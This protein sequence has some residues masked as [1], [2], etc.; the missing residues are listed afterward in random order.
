MQEVSGTVAGRAKGTGAPAKPAATVTVDG[1]GL[2]AAPRVQFG[3]ARLTLSAQGAYA[4]QILSL[5]SSQ[6]TGPQGLAIAASGRVPLSGNGLDVTV[7]GT[8]PLA[9]ANSQL[10]ERGTQVAGILSFDASVTGPLGNPVITGSFETANTQV[11][12]PDSNVRLTGRRARG[13][14]ARRPPARRGPDP[15]RK[16]APVVGRT[17]AGQHHNDPGAGGGAALAG[18]DRPR[19]R[20]GEGCSAAAP[21]LIV[22]SK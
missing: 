15:T 6:V 4:N 11:V 10:A 14:R 3:A 13:G 12:D 21:R 18:H 20:G 1:Q 7:R 22:P 5:S 17:P 19:G 8:V 9:L 16:G 2:S